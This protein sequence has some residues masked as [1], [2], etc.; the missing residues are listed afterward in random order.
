M[1]AVRDARDLAALVR[2][3]RRRRGW[4]QARLAEAAGVSRQWLVDLEHGHER[5]E[6]GKALS[7][8]R[9]LDLELASAGSSRPPAARTWM[10][11][12]DVASAIREELTAGDVDFA[13]RLLARALADL[14]ALSAPADVA[15][16]LAAPPSTGDHRWDT[17]IAAATARACRQ[18]GIAAPAWTAAEP[19]TQWWFPVFDPVLAART[20]Q[21][22]PPDLA[23]RGIWLDE[24]AL[25]VV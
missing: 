21:R 25:A 23:S 2:T 19:L 7:V 5:A 4:S 6:L 24:R 22:T 11:M 20:I 17:L 8:L 1:P 10:T 18:R 9:A 13:L 12:P 3:A 16:A 15:S 14:R